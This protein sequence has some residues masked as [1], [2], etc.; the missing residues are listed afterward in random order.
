MRIEM[1]QTVEDSH[2]YQGEDESG[3]LTIEF[4][5]RKFYAGA[6]YDAATG[7][8]DWPRRAANLVRLGYAAEV[9]GE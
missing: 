6:I 4:D 1:L 2:G 9:V 5:V 7:G 3:N 8:P